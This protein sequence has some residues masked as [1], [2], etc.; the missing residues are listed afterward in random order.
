MVIQITR[1]VDRLVVFDA[2][3]YR[4][5]VGRR[6]SE[7]AL[8]QFDSLVDAEREVGLQAIGYSTVLM[9]LLADI[10]DP[11][12]DDYE[13]RKAAALAAVRHCRI[14]TKAGGEDL[15]V[16]ASSGLQLCLS[17]FDRW[18]DELLET[19]DRVRTVAERLADEPT[20]ETVEEVRGELRILAKRLRA[21]RESFA[22]SLKEHIEKSDSDSEQMVAR[23]HVRR[24]ASHVPDDVPDEEVARMAKW[25]G[26]KFSA[27][28]SM[29]WQIV[30]ESRENGGSL[31]SD[32]SAELLWN[33][34]IAFLVGE[35]HK[36]DGNPATVVSGDDDVVDAAEA[37]GLGRDIISVL[38][39]ADLRE[40]M[41]EED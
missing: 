25:L 30:D 36:L 10:A 20:E 29:Y 18:P 23:A 27:A 6:H 35:T 21:W 24:A 26:R 31:T 8:E 4:R 28:V 3:A 38:R 12:V 14:P 17:L 11:E 9:E 34:Q 2:P 13:N 19:D 5:L 33:L 16:W 15:A 32:R 41:V 7:K 40:D 22:A 1:D 37:C 39:Y